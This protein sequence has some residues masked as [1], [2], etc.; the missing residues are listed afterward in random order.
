[1]RAANNAVGYM[2]TLAEPFAFSCPTWKD[3]LR[4]VSIAIAR[5]ID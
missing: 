3:Q 1:M 5:L 2:H 4:I